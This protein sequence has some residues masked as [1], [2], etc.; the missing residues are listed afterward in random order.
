[1]YRLWY[2]FCCCCFVIDLLFTFI[3]SGL[4]HQ[5][6]DPDCVDRLLHCV[7]SATPMFSVSPIF[8]MKF[9][10]YESSLL[11]NGMGNICASF[12]QSCF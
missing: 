3:C 10:V 6:S 8:G 11:A 2:S 9:Y 1:M 4:H 7:K 12:L 5:A